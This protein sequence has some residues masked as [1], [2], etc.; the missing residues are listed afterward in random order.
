MMRIAVCDDNTEFLNRAVGM[1]KKW[2]DL[3]GTPVEI[4]SFDNGDSLL[5]K[6][7]SVRMDVVFLDIIMPL[8]T[9]MD[10]AR[11]L[12]RS[13][14]AVK[15][16]FLTSS[17]EFALESYEVKAQGYLL[18]PVSYEKIKEVLDDVCLS[19]AEEPKNTVLKTTFGYQKIYFHDIEYAEAQNKRVIFYMQNGRVI[20]AVDPLYSLEEKLTED[21]GFFKC[22][23]SYLVYMPSVDHF[24]A[25]E[26]Y[27][28]SGRNIPIAR[29]YTK[30]FK[31][32]YFSMMFR[33]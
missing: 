31:E 10:A 6:N 32:A 30:A 26:I 23:R 29:G 28:K 2:S 4:Y 15:I 1:V 7:A 9:G 12:R 25:S 5:A 20:Y 27:L 22:H 21:D 33:D 16:I 14:N 17:P 13:D 19:F 8:Q 3:S 11:E 24:D 18:K